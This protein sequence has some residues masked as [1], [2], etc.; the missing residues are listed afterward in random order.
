MLYKKLLLN[1]L[2]V[3]ILSVIIISPAIAQD[4]I[5]KEIEIRG[6]EAISKDKILEVIKSKVGSEISDAVIKNDIG[7]IYKLGF[8]TGDIKVSQEETGD[9][10]KLIF[11]VKENQKIGNINIVGNVTFKTSKLQSL[12]GYKKGDVLSTLSVE[13]IKTTILN[14]YHRDGYYNTE[15]TIDELK[16]DDPNLINLQIVIDEGKKVLVKKV[17]IV[18]NKEISD[19][20]LKL[21][22]STKGSKWFIKNYYDDLLFKDDIDSIKAL[23]FTKGYFDAQAATG[24]FVSDENKG[25]IIPAIIVEEGNRYKIGEVSVQGNSLFSN[26]EITSKFDKLK[27]T[28][29]T[30]DKLGAAIDDVSNLYGDEGYLLAQI[31]PE[32]KVDSETA[33][34]NIMLNIDE[35]STVYVGDVKIK[36]ELDAPPKGINFLEKFYHKY[37]PPTKEE[38]IKREITLKPGEVYRRF[39]E[40]RTIRRLKDLGIFD[41]IK[42]HRAPTEKPNVQDVT[43]ELEEGTTNNL[44]FGAGVGDVT[45]GFGFVSYTEKNLF[46]EAKD[47]SV[48][49]Q[50]GTDQS[51]FRISYLDRHFKDTDYSLRYSIFKNMT[52]RGVYDEDRIGLNIEAG[53]PIDVEID[54]KISEYISDFFNT[55]KRMKYTENNIKGYVKLRLEYV[56][57]DLDD[58]EEIEEDLD[59]YPITSV[60]FGIIDDTRDDDFWPTEGYLRSA[61]VEVGY[62]DGPLVKLTADYNKYWRMRYNTI[63]AQR[64]YFGMLPYDPDTVGITERLFMGG[65]DDLRGFDY[66]GVA[67]KDEEN[68]DMAIGGSTKLLSQ[69]EV[70]FP[71]YKDFKGLVFFDAGSLGDSAF[72]LG[73]PRFSTGLGF[74]MKLP[75]ASFSVDLAQALNDKSED[76]TQTIHFKIS[77]SF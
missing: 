62:A 39:Q 33:I 69:S 28:F 57:F 53:K 40:V 35:G 45:G 75:I 4:S 37:S 25:W 22:M 19:F 71:I 2:F 51:E 23:Y 48:G 49:A 27:N 66:R 55:K 16:T 67:P 5:I 30:F 10:I 68:E 72:A 13:E 54:K 74:R 14:K 73:S 38:I 64:L 17:H 77:S 24:E 63:F 52:D 46:G 31:N 50:I 70:R 65:T 61:G 47:L 6:L 43:F 34:V 1:V 58:D 56:S 18:G 29:F 11:T 60:K 59:S 7:A 12:L 20:R 26:E 44:S 8:F 15:V 9:G 21:L 3:V 32:Y 41:D 42:V 36:R 76:D